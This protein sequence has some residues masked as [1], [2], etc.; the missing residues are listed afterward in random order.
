MKGDLLINGI[1][2]YEKYG[3]NLE[4]GAI[5]ALLAPAP[6]K[7]VIENKSRLWHGSKVVNSNPRYESRDIT[8]PFHIV[9]RS[10]D[11][12]FAKY[13]MFCNEVLSL[14]E[15][16]L[17]TKY[18]SDVYKLVYRSCSQF[19]SFMNQIAIFSLRVTEPNPT[20]RA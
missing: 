3:I 16:T 19:R 14:G 7:D 15:F 13:G 10:Q 9:A 12:F 5:S 20:D 18:N 4:D 11:D 17:Q 1:D 6:M 2:A 8:L